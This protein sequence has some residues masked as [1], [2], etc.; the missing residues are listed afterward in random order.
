MNVS[1]MQYRLFKDTKVFIGIVP[2]K[3]RCRPH[4]LQQ[5]LSIKIL[6]TLSPEAVLNVFS[7]CFMNHCE[8]KGTWISRVGSLGRGET[9][10]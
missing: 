3:T 5:V 9:P 10:R 1:P 6:T 8:N 2:V 4:S 7:S